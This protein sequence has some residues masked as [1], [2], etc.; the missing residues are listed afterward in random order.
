[1]TFVVVLLYKYRCMK[2]LMGY[3]VFATTMLLGFMTGRMWN[4]AID[5]YE[6]SIDKFSFYFVLYNFA[7][8][9]CLAIFYGKGIPM[10]VSQGYLIA[11]SVVL[12]WQLSYFSEWTAW[13]LLVLLA[14]YD[15]FAVLTPCGPLKALVKQMQKPGAP[16]MPGLLY[17]AQLPSNVRRPAGPRTNNTQ[18]QQ[19]ESTSTP[20]NQGT[21]NATESDTQPSI[22]QEDQRHE[23][24]APQN[25]GAAAGE[26]SSEAAPAATGN[27]NTSTPSTDPSS[28]EKKS[29]GIESTNASSSVTA[30]RAPDDSVEVAAPSTIV[31]SSAQVAPADDTVNDDVE[32]QPTGKIPL[33][34]AKTYKL[35]VIDEENVLGGN[36]IDQEAPKIYTPEEIRQGEWTPKQLASLVTALFPPGGGRIELKEPEESDDDDRHTYLVYNRTNEVV[37]KFVVNENGEVFQ[38][39]KKNSEDDTDNTIKLG[40]G[41]FIFYSLLV[42]KA[43]MYSFTTFAACVVVILAGLGATLILLSVYGKALPALPISIF[44]A[45]IFYLLT[46]VVIEPWIHEVFQLPVYV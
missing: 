1:M 6:W 44:M 39:V 30:S 14:C 31:A 5:I 21:D 29:N 10:L 4:I 46:R 41:D 12:A 40:L 25:S 24:S 11:S 18:Q 16:P 35:R 33:A 38:V 17:E 2:F 3:M 36:P 22:G 8:V 19:E 42:S 34:L 9:G 13:T 32:D 7:V 27:T 37:R 26:T 20:S 15:L 43:A 28:E 23:S 45:V